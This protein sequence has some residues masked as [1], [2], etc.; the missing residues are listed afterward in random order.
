MLLYASSRG[1]SESTVQ[2]SSGGQDRGRGGA[3]RMG[4]QVRPDGGGQL[5]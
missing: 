3:F 2:L 1:K 5:G 4:S